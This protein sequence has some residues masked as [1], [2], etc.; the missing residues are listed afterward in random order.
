MK[1]TKSIPYREM[2]KNHKLDEFIIEEYIKN[3]K[4]KRNIQTKKRN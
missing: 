1:R 3:G 2:I 4:P